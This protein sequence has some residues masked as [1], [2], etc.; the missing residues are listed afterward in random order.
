MLRLVSSK[1]TKTHTIE[2]PSKPPQCLGL[3]R[4]EKKNEQKILFK[5][6]IPTLVP[7]CGPRRKVINEKKRK[8]K[9]A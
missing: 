4:R 8:E 6:L 5:S 9:D 7:A 1:N 2:A 3:K